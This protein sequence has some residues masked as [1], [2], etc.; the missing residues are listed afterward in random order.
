V[1]TIDFGTEQ[2]DLAAVD[3]L[4]DSSQLNTI[5]EALV[6]L[7]KEADGL[8][9]LADLL[10]TLFGDGHAPALVHHR[11]GRLA[12]VRPLEVAAA[13]NR[14]RTLEVRQV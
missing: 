9:S 7:H 1:K 14:L 13:L 8:A 3:H 10:R 2:I 6:R 4:V 5:A 11:T 12:A